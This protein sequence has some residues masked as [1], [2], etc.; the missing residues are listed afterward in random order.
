MAT[1]E[2]TISKN[3]KSSRERGQR[4]DMAQVLGCPLPEP[5]LLS[6]DC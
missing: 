4:R 3:P 1:Q 2:D 6:L 5:A